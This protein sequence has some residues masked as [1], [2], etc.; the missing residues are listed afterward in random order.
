MSA[1]G[2]LAWHA[3]ARLGEVAPG[4]A[5]R[6]AA[7]GRAIALF[8]LDGAY[9]ATD[10]TCTHARASLAD[11]YV[12]GEIVECPLH[13]GRFEIRTGKACGAPCTVDLATYPVR[14]EGEAVCVGIVGD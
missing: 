3:V 6:V 5:V 7:A 13:F 10:D 8:N 1:G 12:E 14:V 9:F 4:E 11:G 2:T